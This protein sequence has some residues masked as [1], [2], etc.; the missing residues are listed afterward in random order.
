MATLITAV[1]PLKLLPGTWPVY[2]E[3]GIARFGSYSE[4]MRQRHLRFYL[5]Q[6]ALGL[7]AAKAFASLQSNRKFWG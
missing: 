3:A 6:R 2:A 1:S 7:S 4:W 5:Y